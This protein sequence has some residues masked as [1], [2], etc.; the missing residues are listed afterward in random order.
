M[1]A[2]AGYP[3]S[4]EKGSI[5]SNIDAVR[6]AKVTLIDSCKSWHKTLLQS[7]M[8]PQPSLLH[9]Q[10][11]HAG[12]QLNGSGDIIAVGGRVL[13]VT[14]TGE[15]VAEAQRRAYEVNTGSRHCVNCKTWL[16]GFAPTMGE[17]C[18]P[19]TQYAGIMASA[20]ET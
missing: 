15:D 19:S 9:A 10:V 2:A 18:R 17:T 8:Q 11:F 5:I 6:G 4:Y 7:A 20:E 1:M 16:A 14:A 3:G 13:G 12:T